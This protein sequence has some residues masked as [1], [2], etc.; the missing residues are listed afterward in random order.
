[1]L[2]LGPNIIVSTSSVATWAAKNAT[3]TIPIVMTA[4]ADAVGEG[5]VASLSHPGGNITGMTFLV[6]PAIAGKQLE[7]LRE[8]VPAARR[9]AV[10]A[11]P[12]NK[13]HPAYA[14]ELQA[15][16]RSLDTRLQLVQAS[17]A[18][19]IEGAFAAMTAER[20]AALLVLTDSTF[21]AQR[22]GITALAASS[23]IP[24]L[25]SQ[26]EFVDVGG[27]ASYGPSLADMSRRA[28]THVDKILKGARP[29]DIPVEQPTRFELVI[30]SRTAKSLG[31]T[32][33]LAVLARADEVIR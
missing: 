33:S 20:A 19:Q 26:R 28:A 27:L 6:G 14:D 10:L 24:A 7:L 4:S 17:S 13:A 32:P 16:A 3:R 30:N 21:F 2:G 31:L 25:Y 11:N 22:R 5:L 18:E 29:G 8:V 1:L 9:V 12:T 23:G 15:A